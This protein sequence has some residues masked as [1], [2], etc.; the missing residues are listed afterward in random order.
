LAG[1][2]QPGQHR[3]SPPN[4]PHQ[5][6]GR[7]R[8]SL[9]T[10]T[11]ILVI[12]VLIAISFAADKGGRQTR[13]RPPA[14]GGRNSLSTA[15]GPYI[16]LYTRG[17]PGSYAGIKA[18][19]TATGVNPSV[20]TYYSGWLEPFKSG[21]ARAAADHDAVPLVQ[22]DPE[23]VSIAAIAAGSFDSY[24]RAYAKAVRGYHH[25]V[26]L[27]FGH[28][29]NG[30]WYSWGYTHTTPSVFVAAWRHIVTLFRA[31]RARNVTWLWTVN[32]IHKQTKVPSPGAW[33]PGDSFVSWVG[34]DGYFTDSSAVFA[35]VFGPTIFYVRTLTRR[36][37]LIAETSAVPTADQPAKI[38]ELFAGIHLYDLLGFVWF[39]SDNKLD[40]RLRGPAAIAAFR[41]YAGEFRRPRS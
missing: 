8:A 30:Y 37:I 32:T 31:L 27:S 12:A 24:L 36:P 41:R 11:S 7:R 22:I 1:A 33:W 19:T 25:P 29:M 20:V 28:E 34:I 23:H 17:V 14:P 21:F 26:I 15:P 2:Q 38:A 9:I 40:W 16:G 4:R 10:A 6:T 18:F 5:M 39:D 35:S 13:A 3:Q